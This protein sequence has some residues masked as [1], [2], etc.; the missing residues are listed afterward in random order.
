MAIELTDRIARETVPPAS[1]M[2]L[3]WDSLVRGIQFAGDQSGR[4]KLDVDLP[5]ARGS[6]VDDARLVP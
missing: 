5:L 1:G 2:S 6:E 3:T 4:E